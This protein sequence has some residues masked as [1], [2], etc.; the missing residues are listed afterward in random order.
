M[1]YNLT[2]SSSGFV[3]SPVLFFRQSS[4]GIISPDSDPSSGMYRLAM[5]PANVFVVGLQ[6]HDRI[7]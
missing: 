6:E 7:N 2:L 5:Q 3:D 1:R 4:S